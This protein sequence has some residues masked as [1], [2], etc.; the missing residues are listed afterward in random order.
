MRR[1]LIFCVLPLLASGC[2]RYGSTDVTTL[3][4]PPAPVEVDVARNGEIVLFE[5]T[6]MT[7]RFHTRNR[8][9]D[10]L[11]EPM[12]ITSANSE[13]VQ[14]FL[15]ADS[16]NEEEGASSD[17]RVVV[18]SAIGTTFLR[19]KVDGEVEDRI[20]VRVVAQAD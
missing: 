16:A 2:E 7:A 5:G 11:L 1:L 20:P 6:A 4:G 3:V 8:R 10:T 14:V 17:S 12:E 13:V 15:K 19:V 18:A 9:G